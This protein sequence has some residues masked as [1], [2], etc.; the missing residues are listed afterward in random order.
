MSKIRVEIPVVDLDGDDCLVNEIDKI[1]EVPSSAL[2]EA[3]T[4]AGRALEL[5]RVAASPVFF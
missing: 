4:A 3:D 1:G 2:Q 5:R